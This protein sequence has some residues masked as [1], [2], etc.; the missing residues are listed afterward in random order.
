VKHQEENGNKDTVAV[1][2]GKCRNTFGR[3]EDIPVWVMPAPQLG[4]PWY[5]KEK[6]LNDNATGKIERIL[7]VYGPVS[8]FYK[9]KE[10]TLAIA[11]RYTMFTRLTTADGKVGDWVEKQ[12]RLPD[13]VNEEP[14]MAITGAPALS[15][16]DLSDL[17]VL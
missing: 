16:S 14:D 15:N 3:A 6:V 13:E 8:L 2:A 5:R 4:Q 9:W 1:L 10:S 7:S 11:L 17:E 12:W